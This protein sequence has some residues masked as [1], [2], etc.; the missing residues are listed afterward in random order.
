[1]RGIV[2]NYCVSGAL[3]QVE[4]VLKPGERVLWIG[5]PRRGLRFDSTDFF[6]IPFSIAWLVFCIYWM[7]AAMVE[8][9]GVENPWLGAFFPAFG[10]PFIL[11][12]MHLL[13]GRFWFDARARARTVFGVTDRRVIRLSKGEVYREIA[14]GKIEDVAAWARKDGSGTIR[15]VEQGM[16]AQPPMYWQHI[17]AVGELEEVLNRA[18]VAN[19]NG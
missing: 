11:A 2:L 1:M 16:D 5:Q 6:L 13:V 9:R 14:L 18:R 8:P 17:E 10:I 7:R 12:G 4:R 3:T 15:I 19:E